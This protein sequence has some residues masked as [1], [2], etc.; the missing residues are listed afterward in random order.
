MKIHEYQAKSLLAEHNV[1]VPRGGVAT[2]AT[3]ARAVASRIRP[4]YAVKAQVLVGGRGKAGGIRFAP[5]VDRASEAAEQ[6]L[7]TWIKGLPV[8]SVLIEEAANV[9][10]EIYLAVSIDR[11]AACPLFVASG[12][13]G[14]DIEETAR[15]QSDRVAMLRIDPYVG[16][17]PYHERML[18]RATGLAGEHREALA[19]VLNGLYAAFRSYEATLAEIN[20]LVL[21]SSGRLLAADAKVT[22]DDNALHRHG[23]LVR[24]RD[25]DHENERERRARLAGISYVELKGDIACL[26][27]GAGLAMATIDCVQSRGGAPANFLDIGGGARRDTVA[28]AVRI[29]VST[30]SVR[31]VLA[32]V[33]GG[34]TRCDEVAAGIVAGMRDAGASIP[35]VVRLRGTNETE[36]RLVLARS[37][38][39]VGTADSL[40]EAATM[41]VASARARSAQYGR[42]S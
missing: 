30:P 22:I 12:Q 38:L 14:V 25:L 40:A 11:A 28:E 32:N 35:I 15:T 1:A 19:G 2:N 31:V 33:L 24:L 20:P 36:G 41:A 6:I 34:I 37:G 16:L 13:G 39:S 21:D 18:W 26:V 27:N 29:I 7:E 10:R 42:K 9:E 4:P 23:D 17:R 8:R 5:T 3:E